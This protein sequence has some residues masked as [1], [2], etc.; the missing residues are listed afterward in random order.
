MTETII[1]KNLIESSE[2][3]TN[4]GLFISKNM[5]PSLPVTNLNAKG[6]IA[7]SSRDLIR[8]RASDFAK[9]ISAA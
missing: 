9:R 8:K 2:N 7:S 6:G 3:D 1:F 5:N 4:Y